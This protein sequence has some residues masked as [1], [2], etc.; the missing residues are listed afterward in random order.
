MAKILQL[1]AGD[2]LELKK[3]H[4]C[5]GHTFKILSLGSD[6]KI[7]C[8]TCRHDMTIERIKLERAVKRILSSDTP[9][10]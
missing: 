9:N 3:P 2:L 7:L 5:G 6:V 8:Q 10:T 1:H 4:P